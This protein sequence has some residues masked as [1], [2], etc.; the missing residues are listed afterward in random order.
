MP[1]FAQLLLPFLFLSSTVACGGGAGDRLSQ[2]EC[3]KDPNNYVCFDATLINPYRDYAEELRR[4]ERQCLNIGHLA[5]C[6]ALAL[7]VPEP[8]LK[9]ALFKLACDR[10]QD[11][12]RSS[13]RF[14]RDIQIYGQARTWKATLEAELS[15]K[16]G[17]GT[18]TVALW[19]FRHPERATLADYMY[20]ARIVA[21]SGIPGAEE[22]HQV[23]LH[24]GRLVEWCPDHMEWCAAVL[25]ALA[26]D[27]E[28]NRYESLITVALRR[29]AETHRGATPQAQGLSRDHFALIRDL[30]CAHPSPGL[31]EGCPINVGDDQL[32]EYCRAGAHCVLAY[33]RIRSRLR[34]NVDAYCKPGLPRE[35]CGTSVYHAA[36]GRPPCGGL[37]PRA[38]MN[39]AYS[40]LMQNL[41]HDDYR[42]FLS[43][44]LYKQARSARAIMLNPKGYTPPTMHCLGLNDELID[45][46]RVDREINAHL[47]VMHEFIQAQATGAYL[48]M[49]QD[50][51]EVRC[52]P[53]TKK[54]TSSELQSF[55]QS[56]FGPITDTYQAEQCQTIEREVP[57]RELCP[58]L[59]SM[60]YW[61]PSVKGCD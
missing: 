34:Y 45:C 52:A 25:T 3:Q 13:P 20:N 23:L 5:S 17:S 28:Y 18:N 6:T 58:L 51:A 39:T 60:P 4:L 36:N 16:S 40:E 38:C 35:L 15:S 24:P 22:A 26:S 1:R 61:R 53:V 10:D 49:R 56:G 41:R 46:N 50:R 33:P 2:P 14:A 7:E 54:W 57:T 55:R 21:L 42:T 59:R 12:C 32:F 9:F 31:V 47:R 11:N 8:E 44:Q 37:E 29:S 27:R 30:Y 48:Q 43:D 19:K